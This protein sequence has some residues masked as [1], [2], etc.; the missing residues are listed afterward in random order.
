MTRPARTRSGT[1]PA[2]SLIEL[3]SALAITSV[4]VVGLGSAVTVASLSMP[5]DG[6]PLIEAINAADALSVLADD[7]RYA[8]EFAETQALR[9]RCTV[10]DRDAD[11]SPEDIR[12]EWSGTPGE[13]LLRQNGSGGW[14]TVIERVE[15]LAFSYET[16]GVQSTETQVT[17]STSAE[18]LFASHTGWAGVT[19]EPG[20]LTVGQQ[21]QAAEYFVIDRVAF[22]ANTTS[23]QVTRVRL[24]MSKG[25]DPGTVSVGIHKPAVPGEGAPAPASVGSLTTLSSSSLPASKGW[26]DFVLPSDVVISARESELVIVASGVGGTTANWS[27]NYNRKGPADS[28]VGLFSS[29]SGNTWSPN[30]GK[31]DQYDLPFYAY[32]TY[33]ISSS[34]DV[35]VTTHYLHTVGITL[36]TDPGGVVSTTGVEIYSNPQVTP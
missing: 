14:Q 10:P 2:Y 6:D 12:Y 17:E 35:D 34:S 20:L 28:T 5:Q 32:G 1:R 19:A 26:V 36:Q 33:T 24:L 30:A 29:S 3:V 18:L 31:Q 13:P 15:S 4:L 25:V 11:G 8:T 16:T 23:V 7:L 21:D 9:V 27:Y 22:P